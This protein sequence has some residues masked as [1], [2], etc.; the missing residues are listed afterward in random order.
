MIPLSKVELTIRVV[1]HES[2]WWKSRRWSKNEIVWETSYRNDV[3]FR[4]VGN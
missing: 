2:S 3:F 1:C 4:Y